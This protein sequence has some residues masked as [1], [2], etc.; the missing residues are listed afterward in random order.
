[1]KREADG[2]GREMDVLNPGFREEEIAK[3]TKNGKTAKIPKHPDT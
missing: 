3:I 2:G 1:M